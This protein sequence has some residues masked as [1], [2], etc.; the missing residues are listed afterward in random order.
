MAGAIAAVRHGAAAIP[1]RRLDALEEGLRGRT[2]VARLADR[3]ASGRGRL[4]PGRTRA[5]AQVPWSH[6]GHEL[7]AAALERV[8]AVGR[9]VNR[10][11]AAVGYFTSTRASSASPPAPARAARGPDCAMTR[12]EPTS[13]WS[14]RRRASS[15]ASLAP[16]GPSSKTTSTSSPRAP[17]TRSSVSRARRAGEHSTSSGRI[18]SPL[19]DRRSPARPASPPR[20]RR[21]RSSDRS[22]QLDLA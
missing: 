17:S 15:A 7:A 20:E 12:T 14:A 3:L 18:P 4:D 2:H 21:S 9:Q 5:L 8:P 10:A 19:R 16:Y 22:L 1:T 11:S 13:G 6:V